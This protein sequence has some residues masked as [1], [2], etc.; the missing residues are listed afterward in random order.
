MKT[1]T[2]KYL[3]AIGFSFLVISGTVYA[4]NS[5]LW[6]IS[7]TLL[8]PILNAWDIYAPDELR[9][10][11]EIQPDGDTCSNGQILKKTGADNWDCAT[12]ST[13]GG[14]D[15]SGTLNEITYWVDSDTLGT[16]AVATYPS[17]TELSY[18]KGVTSAIQTQFTAKANDNEV[19]KL[20]GTQ[21][22]SGSK[23]FSGGGIRVISGSG[24]V[25][26]PENQD[27]SD[28]SLHVHDRV[29]NTT[30]ADYQLIGSTNM[31]F[32]AVINPGSST[33]SASRSYAPW[34]WVDST[35]TEAS[36]GAHP[37]VTQIAIKPLTLS[38]GTAT[39]TNA[40]TLYIEGATTGTAAIDNNYALWV[41]GGSVQIDD[42][43]TV[44]TSITGTLI[45][46]ASTATALAGDP[47]DCGAGTFADAINASGTLTCNAVVSADITDGTITLA[48]TA[49]TAGRSLTIATDDILADAELYTDTKCIWF[50]NPVAADDFKSIWRNSTA[51]AFT[52]TE[53]WAESDQTVTFMLQVDD[54]TPA[55]IDSVDLAPAA[56]EA[57][58]TSLDGDTQLAASE[59]LDLAITSVANTPTWVSICFTGTWDD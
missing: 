19:V 31:Q 23:N 55:D 21:T 7:G 29:I 52:F 51:N 27:L 24:G 50:E 38:N 43:L 57:E 15:G 30:R 28:T 53:L 22:I 56:V 49:I 2:L 14:I 42:T 12:D 36:S 25:T 35:I 1:K 26:I 3:I 6:R 13:G 54:G 48:D 32:M 37:L 46:N 47:A 39:T 34:L 18:V 16:L 8:Q 58:D 20:A 59:E 41:D 10:D 4:Q 17:L 9:F 40:A 44:G 33:L 5:S 11:G 45:G